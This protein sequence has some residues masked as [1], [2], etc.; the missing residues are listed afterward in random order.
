MIE[1]IHNLETGEIT[2]RQY[3]K[4]EIAAVEAAR[5]EAAVLAQT[6]ETSAVK[7]AAILDALATATGFSADELRD[8]LN[9]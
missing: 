7:K 3:T 1:R 2:E 9:A 4:S 8:A 6:L 5:T